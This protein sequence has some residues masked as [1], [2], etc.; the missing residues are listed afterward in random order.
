MRVFCALSE[1]LLLRCVPILVAFSQ[2]SMFFIICRAFGTFCLWFLFWIFWNAGV[3]VFLPFLVLFSF[4]VYSCE[5][6]TVFW[7]C[8]FVISR[9]VIVLFFPTGGVLSHC[10]SGETQLCS[11]EKKKEK[12]DQSINRDLSQQTCSPHSYQLPLRCLTD[13]A[14]P[15]SIEHTGQCR[16]D[17]VSSN[18]FHR[19]WV[20]SS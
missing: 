19:H 8:F 18:V 10:P 20:E 5:C 3:C 4:G 14:S 13:V 16:N 9:C 12:N 11:G 6:L 1:F 2:D 7:L 17:F 15:E